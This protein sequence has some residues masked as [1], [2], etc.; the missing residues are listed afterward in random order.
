MTTVNFTDEAQNLRAYNVALLAATDIESARVGPLQQLLFPC[1]PRAVCDELGLNWWAAIKLFEDG[2]LSFCPETTP[3]MDE[4]QEAEL[5]FIGG[6]VIAGCDR[7]MLTSLL[8]SLNRP[9]A[10][11]ASKLYYDWNVRC[12]RVLPEPRMGPE[13]HFADWLEKLVEQKDIGS[14]SGILE[15]THDAVARLRGGKPGAAHSTP[16]TPSETSEGPALQR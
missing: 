2:W 5:R 9:Y 13:A 15:M 3:Q 1:G 16:A 8:A 6:L 12:W 11:R 7:R 4:G 14:L 10:Y